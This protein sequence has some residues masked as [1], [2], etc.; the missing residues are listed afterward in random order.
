MIVSVGQPETPCSCVLPC[1]DNCASVHVG[2]DSALPATPGGKSTTT[3]R[4]SCTDV[5]FSMPSGSSLTT[6]FTSIWVSSSYGCPPASTSAEPS[7]PSNGALNPLKPNAAGTGPNML[8]LLADASPPPPPDTLAVFTSGP[9][10]PSGSLTVTLIH[11]FNVPSGCTAPCSANN[12]PFNTHFTIVAATVQNRP[13][14]SSPVPDQ[15]NSTLP[16]V[17]APGNVSSIVTAVPLLCFA[18]AS[19]KLTT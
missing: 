2:A 10:G 19:L 13:R 16:A 5:A 7:R 9:G 11:S 1:E 8:T 4:K 6:L 12:S 3:S 15:R 17:T 14:F 18:P